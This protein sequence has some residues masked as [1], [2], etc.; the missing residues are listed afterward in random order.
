VDATRHR[1]G[2]AV[3]RRFFAT[4]CNEALLI[5]G[6]HFACIKMTEALRERVW[7]RERPFHRDLLVEQ[8]ADEESR[9]VVTQQAVGCVD[10]GDVEI[11][12]A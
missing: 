8:H 5:H 3:N 7:P 2:E 1:S 12:F 4:T 11:S 6:G 10:A 9:A